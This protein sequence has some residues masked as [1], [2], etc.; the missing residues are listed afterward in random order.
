MNSRR[1]M[2]GCTPAFPWGSVFPKMTTSFAFS[3]FS[4]P[5]S[6]YQPSLKPKKKQISLIFQMNP[7]I[8]FK[9][10]INHQS[11]GT[12]EPV[13]LMDGVEPLVSFIYILLNLSTLHSG[14]DRFDGQDVCPS[15]HFIQCAASVPTLHLTILVF[16]KQVFF[17]FSN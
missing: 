12:C 14:L 7:P 15:S 8:S 3:T 17:S 9:T 1:A 5:V 4:P 13:N 2:L 6:L 11:P 10:F 16:L